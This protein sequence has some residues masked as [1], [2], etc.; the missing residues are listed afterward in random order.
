MENTQLARRRQAYFKLSSAIAQ[1]DNAQLRAMLGPQGRPSS[2]STNQTI[3]IARSKV[4]IKRIPLTDVEYE[5][6][7]STSNIH[8]LPT[9]YNYGFGSAGLGVFREL[10]THIKITNWVLDGSSASF[11]LLYH[12]RVIPAASEPTEVD[13]ERHARYVEYWGANANIGKYLLDRA[14]AKH[15]LVLFLERFPHT[16]AA[17]LLEQPRKVPQVIADMQ[18]AIS[19]LRG[20]GIIH[21]DT[22]FFNMLSDGK[23]AYLADFGLALDKQFALSPAE[24]AFHKQHSWYDYGALL[25]NLGSHLFWIRDSLGEADKQRLS[26]Q[27]GLHDEMKFEDAIAI[28]VDNI[29]ALAADATLNLDQAYVAAIVRYR[30]VISF[31]NT[32][33]AKMRQNNQKDTR[34]QHTTL[35]RLLKETGFIASSTP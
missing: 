35:Q 22:D 31:M 6:M 19:F 29:D 5:H 17:W 3:D 28:L 2:W 26:A 20:K 14:S 10:V 7:F 1:I 25:W 33:Y 9:Y 34:F 13:A 21:F 4:F 27:F 18:A 15:E 23:Q 24:E 12:Y 8:D 30:P 32:F 16:V 11:P